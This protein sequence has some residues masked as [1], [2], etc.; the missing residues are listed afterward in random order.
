[1]LKKNIFQ[2]EWPFQELATFLP[3]RSLSPVNIIQLNYFEANI[4][5]IINNYYFL[6]K[7]NL[8]RNFQQAQ[9][10]LGGLL[11]REHLKKYGNFKMSSYFDS[12]KEQSRI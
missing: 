3:L 12:D 7:K 6:C 8:R 5:I 9:G 4:I 1:M 2:I 11:D 10:R